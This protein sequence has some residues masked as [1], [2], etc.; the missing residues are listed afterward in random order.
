MKFFDIFPKIKLNSFSTLKSKEIVQ[1]DKKIMLKADKNHFGM[2]AA[3]SQSR[4]LD[5]K[6]VL[7]HPLGPIPWSLATSDCTLRKTN[8][9]VL[10]NSLETESMKK[11]LKI[12][13]V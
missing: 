10:S 9:A 13:H 12:W 1:K 6:E 11:F 5:M 3:I 7:S 2:M 8:K 4:N